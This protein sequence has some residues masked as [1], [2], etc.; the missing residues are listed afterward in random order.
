M[1]DEQRD[2]SCPMRSWSPRNCARRDSHPGARAG[3]IAGKHSVRAPRGILRKQAPRQTC[4]RDLLDARTCSL[5]SD[6]VT[7]LPLAQ[8]ISATRS[9]LEPRPLE[10]ASTRRAF[11]LLQRSSEKRRD[12]YPQK[13]SSPLLYRG[14][15][16]HTHCSRRK[17]PNRR[18]PDRSRGVPDA[19]NI[20]A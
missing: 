16:G 19:A 4:V 9:Y 5:R 12:D 6:L 11:P 10:S 18:Q 17:S 8:E 13:R 1:V 7:A 20:P 14:H 15:D 2:R 3:V